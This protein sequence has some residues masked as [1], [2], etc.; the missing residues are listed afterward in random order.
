[1]QR[2]SGGKAKKSKRDRPTRKQLMEEN[3]DPFKIDS[4]TLEADMGVKMI[5]LKFDAETVNNMAQYFYRR[6]KP[7]AALQYLEKALWQ[8]QRLK[9]RDFVAKTCLRACNSSDMASLAC[10]ILQR[11][12][13]VSWLVWEGVVPQ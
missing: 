3:A 13:C 2:K 1:M 9:Q 8:D 5:W 11:G 10:A 7:L 6:N 4:A 12:H